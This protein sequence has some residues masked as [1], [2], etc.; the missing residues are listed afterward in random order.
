M[1]LMPMRSLNVRAR[2]DRVLAR[3]AVGDEQCFMWLR[4]VAHLFGLAH[5]FVVDVEAARGVEDDDVIAAKPRGLHSPRR[6]LL[7]RL[8]LDDWQCVDADLLAEDLELFLRGGTTRIERRH[9]H[10]LF[11]A[12]VQAFCN[13]R[14]GRGLTGTLQAR[15]S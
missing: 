1:P 9:Q 12:L 8:A 4:D 11:V 2:I 3:E 10:F 13:F 15:P 5:Q 7:R 6:D 14:R